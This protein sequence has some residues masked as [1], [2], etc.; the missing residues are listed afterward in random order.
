[1]THQHGGRPGSGNYAG[2]KYASGG[3]ASDVGSRNWEIA[4][5]IDVGGKS[6]GFA[7]G[8][9]NQTGGGGSDDSGYCAEETPE[10]KIEKQPEEVEPPNKLFSETNK[11][12]VNGDEWDLSDVIDIDS[13]CRDYCYWILTHKNGKK[14]R[15]SGNVILEEI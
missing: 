3:G 2:G 10:L 5:G 14:T 1:M 13:T 7:H 15:I 11:L 4:H 6:S 12:Y 8:A 9:G